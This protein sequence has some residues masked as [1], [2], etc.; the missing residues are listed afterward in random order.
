M[1]DEPEVSVSRN[2][3][4]SRFEIHVDGELAGLAAYQ[5]APGML[6]MTHTEVRPEMEGRGLAGI[7][8]RHALDEVRAEG[9]KV[10]PTCPYVQAFLHKHP[11]YADLDYRS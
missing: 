8:V 1:S 11:D 5:E 3:A 9:L 4:E 6:V 2:P 10:L 7:L